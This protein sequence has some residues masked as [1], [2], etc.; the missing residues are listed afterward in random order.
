[1]GIEAVTTE[2]GVEEALQAREAVLFKHSP[3]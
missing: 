3:T 2:A 1:M